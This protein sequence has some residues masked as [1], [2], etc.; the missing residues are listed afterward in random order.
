MLDDGWSTESGRVECITAPLFVLGE[1]EWRGLRG[2]YT[3]TIYVLAL[4]N[5]LRWAYLAKLAF[6]GI[7]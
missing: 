7:D 1:G 5:R 2:G 4:G 3:V 6:R